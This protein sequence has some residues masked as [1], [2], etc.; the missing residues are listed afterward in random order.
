M[1]RLRPLTL[2][3]QRR[4]IDF[5]ILIF[6]ISFALF[7]I[8]MIFESSNVAAF[9]DF[10]DK[11]HFIKDQS[12]WF[13]IGLVCLVIASVIP[14]KKYYLFSVPL[15]IV[16]VISLLAVF[17]P[18][19]GV[20]A[21]GAKRWVSLG[22]INFQPAELAKLTLIFYLSA[23][24]ESKEKKRLVPFLLLLSL[25]VGLVVLEPDLGTGV[26]LTTI[27]IMM[28]FLSGASLWEFLLLIPIAI[29][30]V[31]ILIVSSPYRFKRLTAYFNPNL[32]P[33]GSS[34]HIRQVLITLAS[35]GIYGLGV[36]ASRQKYQF[37]P[38]ATTDSIFA[39]IG[40]EFGFIGAFV[41]IILFGIF[42]YRIF[43]VAK[44]TTDRYGFL[45]AS[46]I[47][48]LFV[49]QLVINLGA[50]VALLPLT[51]VPLPFISY[52]GS[53]LVVSLTAVGII[54]NISRYGV[55]KE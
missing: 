2:L 41:L 29:V 42:L 31:L 14:Y 38:E 15:L 9:R 34:Y 3:K 53:N 13:S 40:E 6:A 51:G 50:I 33:L 46:G 35:G 16:T 5:W 52:G 47:F 22:P 1:K 27:A 10:G 43:K 20:K 19:I 36:G 8:L 23:W 55:S 44:K 28:Y 18:G 45:L 49:S 30:S 24:L 21:Y 11:Y 26:I 17:I 37:L 54:L 39:I 4:Q 25:I 7:G 12:V 48:L 32:D